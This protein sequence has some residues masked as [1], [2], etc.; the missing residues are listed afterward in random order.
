MSTFPILESGTEASRPVE[1]YQFVLGSAKYLFTSAEDD[2]VVGMDTF[3]AIPG[4]KRSRIVQGSDQAR[5]SIKVTMEAEEP[6]AQLYVDNVPGDR[7]QFSLFRLQ[8]DEVPAQ[9]TQLLLFAGIVQSVQFPNDGQ[10]AEFTIKS[11]E[12]ALAKN[13]PRVGF[14]GMCTA[15]LYD[16]VCGADP[17]VHNHIGQVSS[18]LA[19]TITVVGLNASGMNFVSGYAR[20]TVEADYRLVTAQS[21]DVITLLMP[22]TNDPT[23][24]DVQVFAGCDHLL[25][26]D[27][28]LV[29]DRVADFQGFAFV[30]NKNVFD[31]GLN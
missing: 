9:T 23:G 16:L 6:L 7:G 22:F 17:S 12:A 8:R 14:G 19:D 3:V 30:P 15:F 21:G 2:I 26:G 1:L 24:G 20:P 13:V 31:V 5:R 28:A 27:C 4:L 18:I 25:E 11:L 10:T 29:F